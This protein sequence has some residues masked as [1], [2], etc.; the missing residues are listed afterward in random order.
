MLTGESATEARDTLLSFVGADLV[1]AQWKQWRIHLEDKVLTGSG[2][3]RLGGADTG[4]V[5]MSYPSVYN[6]E[7]GPH[8]D[9]NVSG[10]FIF[11]MSPALK[12]IQ[13]YMATLKAHPN[14]PP[15]NITNFS[16]P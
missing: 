13:D 3:Q 1:A 5:N 10:N 2:P 7:M 4:L 8:E 15:A 14:P 11:A 6:V 12:V 9:P 16:N